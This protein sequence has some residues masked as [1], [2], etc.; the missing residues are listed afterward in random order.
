METKEEL[1]WVLRFPPEEPGGFEH[2]RLNQT[3]KRDYAGRY[4]CYDQLGHVTHRIRRGVFFDN[5]EMAEWTRLAIKMPY[6]EVI[7][8]EIKIG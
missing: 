3:Y 7:P 6:L 2:S 8:V 1:Y 4:F 5:R